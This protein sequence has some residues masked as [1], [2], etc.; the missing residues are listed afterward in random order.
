MSVDV[1]TSTCEAEMLHYN[2]IPVEILDEIRSG[3]MQ[4]TK[5]IHFLLN[6]GLFTDLDVFAV[7]R[8]RIYYDQFKDS[9]RPFNRLRREVVEQEVLYEILRRYDL[10]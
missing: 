9:G 7:E 10:V 4:D 5:T 8:L 3:Y 1:R 6:E 2:S